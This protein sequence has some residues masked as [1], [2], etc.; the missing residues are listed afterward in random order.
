MIKILIIEDNV[1]K[2]KKVFNIL[3]TECN[4]EDNEIDCADCVR[5]GREFLAKGQYDLLV[6]DLVLPINEGDSPSTESGIRFLDEIYYNPNINIP[7]HIIGLTE[8]DDIYQDNVQEF[9]D[10]LWGLI[11]FN[12]KNTDWIDKLKS[13]VYYL[14]SFKKRFKEAIEKEFKYDI[15]IITAINLEFEQL[16][17]ICNWE[18]LELPNDPIIYYKCILNT[19]NNN[20][21]KIVICCV[22]QM[23][24]Q[25]AAT[26][27]S[28]VISL[29][30]PTKLFITGICAGIKSS[31]VN[32]GDLV[33]ANQSWNYESGK[34][35]EDDDGK[36][37]FKP[38]MHCLPTDNG[39]LA[40]LTQFTND[41]NILSNIYNDFKG[42]KPANHPKVKYGSVG[43][44]PYVLASTNYLAELLQKDR[45]LTAI[46]MEG[47]GIYKAAQFHSGTLPIFIKGISDLGDEAKSDDYQEYASFISAKFVFMFIYHTY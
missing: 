6:L 34:I 33:V 10:K 21:I 4:V 16:K 8:F 29:F 23:G 20:N 37:I 36:L 39:I 7:I 26:V 1:E 19:K 11:N 25:A 44:G 18:L 38:D 14:Q 30:S 5:T 27:S 35:S 2:F 22:N 32:I 17:S 46:D 12:L 13:K 9:E 47:Y 40:K 24:M 15:A 42:H 31:G 28:K 41:K 3:T 43:S 45:K